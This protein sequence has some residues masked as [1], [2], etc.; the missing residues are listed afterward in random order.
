MEETEQQETPAEA[1]D[2]DTKLTPE[3]LDSIMLLGKKVHTFMGM[4]S[5]LMGCDMPRKNI[6]KLAKKNGAALAGE[7]MR[8]MKHGAAI[9]DEHNH[10]LFVETHGAAL[11]AMHERRYGKK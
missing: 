9:W 1:V 2:D 3:E 5:V 6:L 11:D 4:R 7:N 8:A 10:L